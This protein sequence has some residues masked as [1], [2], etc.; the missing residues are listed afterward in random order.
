MDHLL[1]QLQETL[2]GYAGKALNG[3][4]YLTSSE[5]NT[6]FGI[7]G[8]GTMQGQRFTVT[9]L[10]VRLEGNLIIIERDAND[11]P[12]VDALLQVGIPREQI[13]LAY[14]GE[15]VPEFSLAS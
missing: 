3:H 5:D 15:P 8:V 11:K 2:R 6:I 14:A 10:V 1:A 12:L 7:V 4:T 9:G 13:I